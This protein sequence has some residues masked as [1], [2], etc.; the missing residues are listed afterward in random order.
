M[1]TALRCG[2]RP[3]L[4]GP[5][6]VRHDTVIKR[7]EDELAKARTDAATRIANAERMALQIADLLRDP[8]ERARRSKAGIELVSTFPNE[9]QMARRVEELLLKLYA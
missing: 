1:T 3:H 4:W 6:R 7:I 9:E 5:S 2:D 8:A